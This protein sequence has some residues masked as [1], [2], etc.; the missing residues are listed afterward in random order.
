[1]TE[2]T[3]ILNHTW[4]KGGRCVLAIPESAAWLP[5]GGSSPRLAGGAPP[6]LAP[7]SSPS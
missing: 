5:P 6:E 4:T 3:C 2:Q 7:E 1:M